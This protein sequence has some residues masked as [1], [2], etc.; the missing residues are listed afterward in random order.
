MRLSG[1]RGIR[2]GRAMRRPSPPRRRSAGPRKAGRPPVPAG[3]AAAI[4][5]DWSRP[6]S[7][8]SVPLSWALPVLVG[9]FSAALLLSAMRTEVRTLSLEL[10]RAEREQAQ[11]RHA[12][13]EAE[14][15]ARRL[16]HP[17]RLRARAAELGLEPAPVVLLGPRPAGSPTA[18]D[19]RP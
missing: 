9:L 3:G 8:P 13:R 5:R 17:A 14:V 15:R 7:R 10:T 4:P 6:A 19:A 18:G 12:L 1:S 2:R 11:L 16:R